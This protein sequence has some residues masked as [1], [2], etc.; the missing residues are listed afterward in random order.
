MSRGRQKVTFEGLL[1]RNVL[2]IFTVIR[3]FAD[4]RDL[5][6]V[7]V[8]ISYGAIGMG[9]GTGMRRDKN[10]YPTAVFEL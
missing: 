6:D 5:A 1:Q 10:G 9:H 4:L 2:G 3:G 7:S 8:A